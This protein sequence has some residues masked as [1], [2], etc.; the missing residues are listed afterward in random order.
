MRV[1]LFQLL[2]SAVCRLM[3]RNPTVINEAHIVAGDVLALTGASSSHSAP[4][5]P[6]T[7]PNSRFCTVEQTAT[8]SLYKL[9]ATPSVLPIGKP[10]W[11]LSTRYRLLPVAAL[12]YH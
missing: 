3:H 5:P 9:P 8:L 12:T 6:R 4:A 11:I 1:P 7:A 2:M 10:L